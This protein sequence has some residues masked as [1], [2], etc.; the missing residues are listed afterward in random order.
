M[1]GPTDPALRARLQG[2]VELWALDETCLRGDVPRFIDEVLAALAAAEAPT[3]DDLMSDPAVRA[4]IREATAAAEAA[5]PYERD[6]PETRAY[7]DGLARG[8]AAAE[9]AP[10]DPYTNLGEHAGQSDAGTYTF[11]PG[12]KFC[13]RLF[14]VERLGF[15]DLLD[16]GEALL[17]HY[18]PDTIVCSHSVKADVGAQTAA[19]IAD[20]IASCRAALRSPDTETAEHRP[21]QRVRLED[22]PFGA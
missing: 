13:L 21:P 17:A 3:R 10:L 2:V 15:T 5:P 1:T 22:I 12:C 18:P 11:D 14:D 8:M 20:V 7:A 16:I 6:S 9:A 4:L 19:G